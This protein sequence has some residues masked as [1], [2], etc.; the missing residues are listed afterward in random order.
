MRKVINYFVNLTK[1]TTEE[2]SKR[3]LALYV[4]FGIVTGITYKHVNEHNFELVLG[5]FLAFV[6]VLL[7]VATWGNRRANKTKSDDETNDN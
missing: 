3:F 1:T 5:E 7:G 2:S 6:L 4:V